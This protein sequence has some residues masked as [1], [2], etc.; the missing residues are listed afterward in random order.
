[1][2]I[3]YDENQYQI[4]RG[5]VYFDRLDPV[6]DAYTGERAFGNCPGITLNISSEKADHYSSESG[7]AQKDK[8]IAV[9]IDRAGTLNCDNWSTANVALFL[10][11]EEDIVTQTADAVTDE[12]ITVHQGLF[13]QLGKTLANPAGH[14]NVSA[15]VIS[16]DDAGSPGDPITAAG[17]YEVDAALGR[18]RI[19]PGG[20]IAD[21]DLIHVAY[22]KPATTWA[23]VKTGATS[24][25]RG[26]LRVIADNASGDNRDFYMPTVTLTSEGDLPIIAEG[27]EFVAMAFGLEVLKPANGEAIYVDGR[28]AA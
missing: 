6:T 17:N 19:V 11:G 4:P 8:S 21:G 7:L 3:T 12:E 22:A 16:D 28:P 13:Y 2:A 27:T 24:E 18:I 10:S 25:I 23:R 26:A 5:R 14:R 20:A 9:R 1:M 15:V